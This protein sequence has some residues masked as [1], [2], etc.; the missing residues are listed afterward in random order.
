MTP[1]R[2]AM[3][4][5][6]CIRFGTNTFAMVI[7]SF[8]LF[9]ATGEQ[10]QNIFRD[11]NWAKQKEIIMSSWKI[12]KELAAEAVRRYFSPPIKSIAIIIWLCTVGVL[13]YAFWASIF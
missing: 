13:A 3:A 5:G 6:G 7:L 8:S 9:P 1:L 12:A 2:A 4:L 10:L 11:Q